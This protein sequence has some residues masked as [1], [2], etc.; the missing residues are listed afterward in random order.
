M[1]KIDKGSIAPN[2]E[3]PTDGGKIVRLSDFNGSKVV[4]YFYPADDTKGCT[5]EAVDFSKHLADF[6]AAGAFVIGVS[7]DSVA[8]HD[9]FKSKHDL[10]VSLA[11]DV[12]RKAIE[13][14][15]VW[16]EKQ[17][18][19]RKFM[20]VERSTFLIDSDGRVARV[21]RKVKVNG[22]AE[23]VLDATRAL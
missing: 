17:M 8:S 19:G 12:D 6:E 18:Y 7:P 20:G 3:L 23:D 16:V 2:F 4:V 10:S 22:H 15:G 11:A 14:Y 5:V 21:W 13:P 9:K 1:S